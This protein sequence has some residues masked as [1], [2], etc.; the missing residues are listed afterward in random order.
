MFD[1]SCLLYHY[2]YKAHTSELLLYLG[3]IEDAKWVIYFT[4]NPSNTAEQKK[5]RNLYHKSN[6]NVNKI[7]RIGDILLTFHANCRIM[8][9]FAAWNV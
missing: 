4:K 8:S 3:H 6:I 5:K 1:F 7:S 9:Q 2:I